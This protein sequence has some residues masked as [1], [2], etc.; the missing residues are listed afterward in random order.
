MTKKVL[1]GLLAMA[2]LAGCMV[3]PAPAPRAILGETRQDRRVVAWR[4][5]ERTYGTE[6]AGHAGNGEIPGG[7]HTLVY[8]PVYEEA[9]NQVRDYGAFRLGSACEHEVAITIRGG[10]RHAVGNTVIAEGRITGPEG[11]YHVLAIEPT[12]SGVEILEVRDALPL[13]GKR[14]QYC[15]EGTRSFEVV[16]TSHVSGKSGIA[17]SIVREVGRPPTVRQ[18]SAVWGSPPPHPNR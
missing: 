7:E 17:I 6:D 11:L 9:R 1:P 4:L 14:G 16:F 3:A 13:A 18:A 12:V 2:L 15:L 8:Q 5:V 10:A